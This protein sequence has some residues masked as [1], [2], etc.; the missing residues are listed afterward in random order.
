LRGGG[1]GNDAI[2]GREEKTSKRALTYCLYFKGEGD[3]MSGRVYL[4]S[5][6][7]VNYRGPKVQESILIF[8]HILARRHR[9]ER[10]VVIAVSS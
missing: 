6:L 4:Y 10:L 7:L 9:G 1:G 2:A 5:I 3:A 8:L